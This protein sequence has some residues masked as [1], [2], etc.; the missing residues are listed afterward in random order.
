M[1]SLIREPAIAAIAGCC[2]AFFST[3]CAPSS[4][5]RTL[6][7][8]TRA[9]LLDHYESHDFFELRDRLAG[10]DEFAGTPTH[11]FYSALLDHGFNRL[12]AS[13]RK[14]EAL[15]SD[16]QLDPELHG[17]AL[18]LAR[19]NYFRLHRYAEAAGM[20]RQALELLTEDVEDNL[21]TLLML[22]AL[23]DVPPQQVMIGGSSLIKL[24]TDAREGTRIPVSIEGQERNYL[25]DTGANFS[26]LMRS[27]AEV[28]GLEI[29][30]V[31]ISVGNS[32]GGEVQADLAVADRVT[33]GNIEYRY[34]VFLVFPDELLSF[35]VGFELRGIVGFPVMEA[36]GEVRFRRETI[37]I[38]ADPPPRAVQNLF[39]EQLEPL[40]RVGYGNDTL[41]C[42]FDTGANVTVFYEPFYRRYR[43]VVE[44]AGE[45]NTVTTAGVGQQRRIETYTLPEI[46]LQ[47]GG[48]AVTLQ[49]P[50]VY[51]T[52]LGDEKD[53]YL[54]CNLGQ[55]VLRHFAEY[56]I[57][58]R[59]M[60]LIL[61]DPLAGDEP[62]S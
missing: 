12:E 14:L 19:D 44:A 56:V 6:D 18:T 60:S 36:M 62:A 11:R 26:V 45:K 16:G 48:A 23:S 32:S 52:R 61:V 1:K 41:L 40:I 9:E 4:E 25:F 51:T 5:P 38:P 30:T 8:A 2:L 28:L 58:F 29:R 35:P 54:D 33:I 20:A 46:E 34:V 39:F 7:Q 55:D 42:R 59:S 22:E 17:R 24:D 49:R 13:S 10:L 21:N 27:E 53:N 15:L 50:D 37:E 31:G 57:N 43:R 47:V 3:T